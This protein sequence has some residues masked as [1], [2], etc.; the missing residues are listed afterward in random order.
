MNSRNSIA[1]NATLHCLAGCAIGEILGLMIG[2][3]PGLSSGVTIT[4]AVALAFLF[5]YT[6][7]TIP[8]VK[9]GLGLFAASASCSPPTR[10]PSRS[11]SWPTTSSWR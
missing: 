1:A 8:L 11:W 3:A 10:C 6:L 4:L 9:A 5:G 7:S 2:T